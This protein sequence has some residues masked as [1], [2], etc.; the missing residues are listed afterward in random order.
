MNG[1]GSRRD[2]PSTLTWPLAHGLEERGL[3][4]RRRAVDLV[5]QQQLGEDRA[6]AEDHLGVA[7]VVQRRADHVAGQQV[8]GELDAREV[9]AE[10]LGERPGD[11]RLAEAG[12]VLEQD[13]AAGQDADEDQLQGAPSADDRRLE[14]VEDGARF[15]ARSLPGSQLLQS[16]DQPGEGPAG[17]AV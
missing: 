9:E 14:L 10:H 15:R 8:G 4:L 12:Q 7:L 17:N 2:S 16:G 5:G 6:W 13:V 11:E 3:G 1:C